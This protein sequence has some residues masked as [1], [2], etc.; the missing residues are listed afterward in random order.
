MPT[1]PALVRELAPA[2]EPS[3][4]IVETIRSVVSAVAPLRVELVVTADPNMRTEIAGSFKAWGAPQVTVAAGHDLGELVAR[5]VLGDHE[6]LIAAVHHNV[7]MPAPGVLTVVLADG[8]AGLTERAPLALVDGAEEADAWCRRV[9]A[10]ERSTPAVDTAWLED[11][12]V[13]ETAPWCQLVEFVGK[14]ECEG[15]LLAHDTTLGVGRY[16]G[17]MRGERA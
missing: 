3:Q 10:G 8:S 4:K 13:M 17:L 16:V 1:S 14:Y 15:T 7:S 12:G 6:H 5:Y 11:R 9:A 2:H